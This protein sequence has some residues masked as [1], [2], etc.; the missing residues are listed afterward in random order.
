M[1]C[2]IFSAF[3]WEKWHLAT[4]RKW[5]IATSEKYPA[6]QQG[7]FQI[8]Q[9]L[10]DPARNPLGCTTQK[11]LGALFLGLSGRFLS[12]QKYFPFFAL[13]VASPAVQSVQCQRVS[14]AIPDGPRIP[15]S[16]QNLQTGFFRFAVVLLL[17]LHFIH[18]GIHTGLR[19]NSSR[20][21]G[22]VKQSRIPTTGMTKKGKAKE[23][24]M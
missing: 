14:S 13:Q 4:A 22:N 11:F 9:F 7:L 18:T 23:G 1:K 3:L 20:L 17:G 10:T 8:F 19:K 12:T 21:A 16:L 15:L 5:K 24:K 6:R 2:K